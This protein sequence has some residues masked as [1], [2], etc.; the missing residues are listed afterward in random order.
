MYDSKGHCSCQAFWARQNMSYQRSEEQGAERTMK[1]IE[2]ISAFFKERK[3]ERMLAY[4]VCGKTVVEEFGCV[5]W[6]EST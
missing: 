5:T 4:L 1:R 3:G 2:Y 6:Q